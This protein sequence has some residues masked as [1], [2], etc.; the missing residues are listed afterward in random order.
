MIIETSK[1]KEICS[2]ILSAVDSSELSVITETLQIKAENNKLFLE[3]T[4][5]EYFARINLDLATSENFHATVNANLFLK[6]ISQVTTSD[7]E[8][9]VTDKNLTVKANGTYKLPLI[10]DNDK[11]LELPEIKI[12][13]ITKTLTINS[14]ILNSILTYNSKELTRGTISRP[15][16]KLY[17]MDNE[18]AITF[19]TGACVNEFTLSEPL[20]VLL[21]SRVVK[22]FKLFQ[23]CDVKV[24]LGF[25]EVSDTITQTKM[26]F[27]S[28]LIEITAILPSTD[29][30]LNSVPVTAIRGMANDIYDYSIVMS[31]DALLQT[32]NRL[33]L[34]NT[35][36]KESVKPYSTF[37][38]KNDYV[39]VWDI[40]K[41]NSE[42]ISYISS[43]MLNNEYTAVLDL[44]DLK[45]VLETSSD[46]YVTLNFGNKRSFVIIKGKIKNIIPEVALING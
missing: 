36:G 10:F 43:S 16:Q 39:T 22:L 8:L 6:L 26:S 41:Q 27:I 45:A 18:G 2:K 4:N 46:Q 25:D 28:D 9:N 3:V 17:Y 40:D 30:M 35:I 13:N 15:V 14:S 31:K 42:N 11:L 20:R 37:E 33:L 34:F 24:N 32:I 44:I 12:N 5:G 23:D 21:T 29:S 38:F 19:T 7:I 1:L